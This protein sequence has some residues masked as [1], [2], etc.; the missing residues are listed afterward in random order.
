M[1]RPA[2]LCLLILPTLGALAC[3]AIQASPSHASLAGQTTVSFSGDFA[4]LGTIQSVTVGGIA[5]Y[6]LDAGSK[7]ITATLQG[8]ST[9]G[10][11]AIVV[12]GSKGTLT[13]PTAFT[14]DPPLAH[15]PLNWVA[16]GASLTMGFQSLGLSPHSQT[17]SAAAD[18]AAAAGVNLRLP[19]FNPTTLPELQPS[20]FSKQCVQMGGGVTIGA[21]ALANPS[22]ARIDPT[23]THPRNVAIGGS[24]VNDIL[25]G[26]ME[27]AVAFQE[28]IVENP[29]TSADNVF[30]TPAMSQIDR[31]VAFDPDVGIST[32]IL[33]NDVDGSVVASDDLHPELVTPASDVAP[34]L[35]TIMG[36]LGKLHGQ[37]FIATLPDLTFIP[38]V[39][40]L[41]ASTIMNGTETAESFDTKLQQIQTGTDALNAALVAAMMPYPNLHV[42][43]F[44]GEAAVDLMKGIVVNG[45]TLTVA[46]FG[47]LLSLDGLHFTDTG[48]AVLANLFIDTMNPILRTHIPDIDLA[49]VLAEDPL[50]PDKLR[51]QGY[52]CV[53]AP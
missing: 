32:D 17:H 28:N 46:Q 37:F 15:V 21:G 11:A 31:I 51:A 41:R 6:D 14:Y 47:G 34:L 30:N 22:S 52:T 16:F 19:L 29:N 3:N 1:F 27:T 23:L 50:S 25:N 20:D 49:K 38:N 24:S 35:T 36:R 9:P 40:A 44:H 4:S 26:G 42:V 2:R 18:I 10:P 8:G 5:T 53:P 39:V 12:T 43:D 7:V 45:E 48:Y 13:A 33:A